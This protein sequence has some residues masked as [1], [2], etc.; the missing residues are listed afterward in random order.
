MTCF[1]IA[2]SSV[3]DS[4][5]SIF[6]PVFLA[7]PYPSIVPS[8]GHMILCLHSYCKVLSAPTRGLSMAPRSRSSTPISIG[9]LLPVAG[10]SGSRT[11]SNSSHS[12]TGGPDAFRKLHAGAAAQSVA[13]SSSMSYIGILQDRPEDGNCLLLA[14]A[15]RSRL[16]LEPVLDVRKKLED[17]VESA[18]AD[19]PS[20]ACL[21]ASVTVIFEKNAVLGHVTD[22]HAP[23]HEAR[24]RGYIGVPKEYLFGPR[25]QAEH[26]FPFRS[27]ALYFAIFLRFILVIVLSSCR[28]FTKF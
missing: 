9:R 15:Q 23:D 7:A 10:V 3:F 5:R 8:E 25:L 21:E 16:A 26:W 6:I 24:Q 22:T 20:N 14:H 19:R 12:R 2:S 18:L 1:M 27:P 11:L 28:E 17:A 13:G 4:V